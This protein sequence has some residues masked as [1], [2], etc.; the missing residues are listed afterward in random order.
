M[1]AKTNTDNEL[2]ITRL[3]NAPIDLVWEVWT[4][5]KHIANWWGPTGF[6]TSIQHMEVKEGG[7][8]DLIMHGPDGVD[9][10][11]KNVF[12]KVIKP[13]LIV[14]NHVTPPLFTTTITF[15]KQGDHTELTMQMVFDSVADYSFAVNKHGAKA[16]QQQTIAKLQDYLENL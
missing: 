3:L 13:E 4:D 2:I 8:W 7:E 1:T 12:S 14:F 6:T 16:G 9:Y 5:P 10:K 15:K 11:N